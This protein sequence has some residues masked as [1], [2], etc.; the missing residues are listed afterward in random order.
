MQTSCLDSYCLG[1]VNSH[2]FQPPEISPLVY[3]GAK[4][5]TDWSI[6]VILKTIG[7]LNTHASLQQRKASWESPLLEGV[8]EQVSVFCESSK[9]RLDQV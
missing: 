1:S 4:D 5:G 6:A 3:E 9:H 8:K 7:L 2:A